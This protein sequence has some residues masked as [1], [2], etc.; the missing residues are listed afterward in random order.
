M[1][2]VASIMGKFQDSQNFVDVV[3]NKSQKVNALYD[4]GT[5]MTLIDEAEFRKIPVDKRPV[6]DARAPRLILENADK[7][8]MSVRG[9][10]ILSSSLYSQS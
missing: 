3:V 4:P 8:A 7:Q 1:A 10:Y 5:T 9:C 6:Q 2:F